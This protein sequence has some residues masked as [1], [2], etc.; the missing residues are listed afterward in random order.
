MRTPTL[1]TATTVL[2]LI[3]STTIA[4]SGGSEQGGER[5]PRADRDAAIESA[6][7]VRARV[8]F[9]RSVEGRELRATRLGDRE[10][11]RRILVVGSIHGDETEGH[12]IVRLLLRRDR[13]PAGAELWVVKSVNP[14]GAQAGT[15]TNAA[16]V[17]LNRNFPVGWSSAEPPGSDYYGGPRPF[18]E[19]ESRAV[20][21]LARRVEPRITIWYHQPWGVVLLPC[22]GPA[23]VEKRYARVAHH[24]TERCRGSD[25]PGTATRWERQHFP[26]T[27]FVVELEA[28]ELGGR[29]VRRH[30]RAALAVAER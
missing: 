28:G 6:G 12:E 26:G 23:R 13:E 24:P 3:G 9:G 8:A 15:R 10:S 14:D 27:H 5:H 1:L 16:R 11:E 30:T 29:D 2:A 21:R 4:A 18:S 20:R 17:D 7:S 25:L 19:P 22:E